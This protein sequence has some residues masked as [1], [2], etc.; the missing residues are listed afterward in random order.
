[1]GVKGSRSETPT[2]AKSGQMRGTELQQD[3]NGDEAS[4]RE[5][6][7]A[8]NAGATNDGKKR[9]N[10][11]KLRQMQDRQQELE[12]EVS[13]VEAEIAQCESGLQTFVSAQETARLTE[14]LERRRSELEPLVAEW[15]ALSVALEG[16][17]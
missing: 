14:L 15:E 2:S 11:I 3:R 9:L 5:G 4:T 1:D 7:C 8:T 16:N 17:A 13:R 10:P 6:A 12:E